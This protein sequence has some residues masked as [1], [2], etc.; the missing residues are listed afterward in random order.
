MLK[1]T[2]VSLV[3]GQILLTGKAIT[4]IRDYC[5]DASWPVGDELLRQAGRTPMC[6]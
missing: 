3:G 5:H 2:P 1:F 6:I 4:F